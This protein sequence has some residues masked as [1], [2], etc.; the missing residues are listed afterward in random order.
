[1]ESFGNI[2]IGNI[3]LVG[4]VLV[5]SFMF[6]VTTASAEG[7][8]APLSITAE[9]PSF[10]ASLKIAL[11]SDEKKQQTFLADAE[12]ALSGLEQASLQGDRQAAARASAR[13][14]GAVSRLVQ[15][16]RTSE[17]K[18]VVE[19]TLSVHSDRLSYARGQLTVQENHDLATVSIISKTEKYVSFILSR[20]EREDQKRAILKARQTNKS[21]EAI[22]NETKAEE[23]DTSKHLQRQASA[24]LMKADGTVGDTTIRQDLLLSQAQA[25][26]DREDYREAIHLA[27]LARKTA[28]NQEPTQERVEK[29]TKS[30]VPRREETR[31]NEEKNA[32]RDATP[33]K[34][35][36]ENRMTRPLTSGNSVP[37]IAEPSPAASLPPGRPF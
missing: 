31:L 19:Q 33:A 14:M 30:E 17:N 32:V 21:D 3:A 36:K 18:L 2:G 10:F 28:P 24:I 16:R 12:S 22:E 27:I 26:Y 20:E 11:L 23:A 25:A 35:E 29:K 13:Y 34:S 1:M 8:A 37:S 9:K 4:I 6:A 15:D 5:A 7:Q